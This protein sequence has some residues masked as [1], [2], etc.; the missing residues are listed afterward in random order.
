[1]T[2]EQVQDFPSVDEVFLFSVGGGSFT[3]YESLKTVIEQIGE[4]QK[5]QVLAS[6]KVTYGCDHIFQPSEFLSEILKLN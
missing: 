4:D 1:M 6:V 5:D 2:G 3:E